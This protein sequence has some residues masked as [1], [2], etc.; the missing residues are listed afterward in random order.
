MKAPDAHSLLLTCQNPQKAL[1]EF[2]DAVARGRIQGTATV[3]YLETGHAGEFAKIKRYWLRIE[4]QTQQ[5]AVWTWGRAELESQGENPAIRLSDIVFDEDAVESF[6][7][8]RKPSKPERGKKRI[9]D[10]WTPFWVAAIQLAKAGRLNAGNFPTKKAL[11][12]RLHVMMGA[13]MDIQTIKPLSR[14]IY[15]EVLQPNAVEVEQTVA[16]TD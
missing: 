15:E 5:A 6:V 1:T 2:G 13:T 16:E 12:D 14:V 8:E 10:D 3:L 11:H 7:A 9:Q 4:E